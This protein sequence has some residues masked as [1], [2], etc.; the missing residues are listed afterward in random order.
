MPTPNKPAGKPA[1]AKQAARPA[2]PAKQ[3]ARPAAPANGNKG[4]K[5]PGTAV[6]RPAA[7]VPATAADLPDY[8]RKDSVRGSEDVTMQDLTIPRI[9]LVQALSPALKEGEAGYIDGA[10]Q[11]DFFNSVTRELY[12]QQVT[13]CPVLFR[14]QY[15]V[16]RDRKK[17]GGFGGAFDTPAEAQERIAQEAHAEEWEAIETAQQIVLA[18]NMETGDV[19]EAVVSMARTKMK[20]SRQWNS[21]IRQFGFDRFSRLYEL[22]SVDETNSQ[23]QDYKNLAVRMVAFAPMEVYKQAEAL[24]NSIASGERVVKVDED[25]EADAIAGEA[26]AAPHPAE[27]TEY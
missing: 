3:A 10:K 26:E 12:G 8:M 6:A 23:N 17:G 24:Y 25:Y 16:W 27:S 11:G 20:V 18:V 2:A 13:V 21:L 19:S 22:F 15:L 5:P 4:A 9:E 14:K 7:T 1:P